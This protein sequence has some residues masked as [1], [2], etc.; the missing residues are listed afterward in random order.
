MLHPRRQAEAFETRRPDSVSLRPGEPLIWRRIA[1]RLPEF[2]L[3]RGDETVGDMAK[4]I[5]TDFTAVGLC[6]GEEWEIALKRRPFRK[7]R[8]HLEK[9][10]Q[11]QVGCTYE[12]FFY[13][14]GWIKS[15]SGSRFR[16]RTPFARIYDHVLEAEAGVRL[17]RFRPA[18]LRF[19]RTET[20]VELYPPALEILELPQLILLSWFLRNHAEQGGRRVF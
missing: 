14:R 15:P 8:I 10:D 12:G 5:R 11:H 3:L 7:V 4:S 18:F 9:P 19:F 20:R 1:P 17:M 2:E 13:G 6:L 16:W